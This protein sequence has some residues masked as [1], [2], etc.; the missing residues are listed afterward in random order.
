MDRRMRKQIIA[1]LI[2]IAALILLLAI[3]P[4]AQAS[5][6]W[7]DHGSVYRDWQHLWFSWLGWKDANAIDLINSMSGNW[8]G[9]PVKVK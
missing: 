8:W 1:T 2:M 6:N 3:M 7:R 9:E 5:D 4:D